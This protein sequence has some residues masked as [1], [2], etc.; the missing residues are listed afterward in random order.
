MTNHWVDI[1]NADLVLI[2]GGNAAEAHPCGFKWVIEAKHHNKAKLIVVDPRF[3]RSAAMSDYYAPIRAGSDIAFLGGVIN[4]L[5][6]NN[7]IQTEYV[8][9]YTNASFIVGEDYKFEAGIF[10][11]YD[12]AKR[13][14]DNKSWGYELDDKGFAKVDPTLEHPRCVLNIMKAHYSR[15]SPE[16]VSKITGTPKDKFLKVCEMIAETS[17][18]NK[19]MTIMYA[20][21]WTQHSQGSQMIRTGAIMQLLLG[22]IGLPGGGMNALRGHSNIQGLTD[23]GLLSTSLTGYM[24]L[25]RDSEQD[26]ETYYKTRALKPLRP[27]QM[28]FWQNYPK[29]FVSQ[30]KAWWGKA[31]TAENDWAFHYLPKWDKGYD[32]L[33]TFELMGQG[34]LNGYICQGFNPVGSF[35]NKKKIIGGLSKLKFLVVIDPLNTETAEFWKNHGEHNDVKSEDIQTTVFRFPSTCFAEE[36]GSLTNSGRWLQWH[37]KGAEP[38]GEAKGDPEIIAQLFMRMKAAYVKEGGA[39]P[40]PI[41]N[42]S[43][44]YLQ[45]TNPSAEELAKE[46]NGKALADVTDPKDATKV[47]AKAGEQL[48]GF[49]LLRDDGS[50]SSGCW[51]YA[52]AWTQAGNQMARRDNADPYGIGQT[53]AWA[54]AWPANRRVLYNAAS[55][56]PTGK[57]WNPKRR[58]MAWNGE[59]W[60]GSDVPDIR[61]DAN[62]TD[63]DAVRPFIMTAEGVARLFA[64]TGLVDGP[65]PEH[66]E[67]FETPLANNPMHPQNAK[68]KSNPAARVFKGDMEAF[69][70]PK[71][72]PYVATSYRLTEHF[73][74][75]TKNVLTSAVLQPQQFV[76]IGEELAK[77]KGVANGDWVKVTSNRG[78]IKAVAVVT[79]R[80]P[81]LDVDGKRIHTVGLP[82][83]WGFVGVAKPGYLVNTLTPFVGDANTQTPEFKSFTVNLEK[84]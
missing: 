41:V 79:K 34:K 67:P 74:Y 61:P 2:M 3:T 32:V 11:G 55:C 52:G 49:G 25:A 78:F 12:E 57:P 4:Y 7:K 51:I 42:L 30:Q 62:P 65:L 21:G 9:A 23:L 37:W 26:L 63:A 38:P 5:L 59:R 10:S 47:L 40:D 75:W 83:H 36:D 81:S 84:A 29:F 80:I 64:P 77:E 68:A 58:L 71:D 39:F 17:R 27:G 28:S 19:V 60:G 33:Q 72:F 56:D 18:P 54:W 69:G 6:T 53:L 48:S 45:P 14:Y 15:Y 46:Y 43:W 31:A 66:Y 76:E 70:T 8:K 82:N 73:H 13:R 22:N 1:K 35:P 16:Q 24:S 44:P 20:L 50:T